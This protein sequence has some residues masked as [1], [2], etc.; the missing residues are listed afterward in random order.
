LQV[1]VDRLS[2]AATQGHD[3][4]AEPPVVG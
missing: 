4:Q 3:R 1:E 2:A